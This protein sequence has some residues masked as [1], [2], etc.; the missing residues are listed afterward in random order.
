M[1]VEGG[2]R[3]HTWKR[4][5]SPRTKRV[6]RQLQTQ[7]LSPA[8]AAEPIAPG[9]RCRDSRRPM[10]SP[11]GRP[12][13]TC[14]ARDCTNPTRRQQREQGQLV[15]LSPKKLGPAPR[16]EA[17][18]SKRLSQLERENARLRH[19]LERAEKNSEVQNRTGRAVWL[20]GVPVAEVDRSL[21]GKP[22]ANYREEQA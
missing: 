18:R 14:T 1:T 16:P 19:K 10:P 7:R 20:H 12:A 13:P 22:P 8:P 4:R 5:N 21:V 17:P 6:V 2:K 15:G 3:K 9:S 11:R